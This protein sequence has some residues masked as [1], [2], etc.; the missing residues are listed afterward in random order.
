MMQKDNTNHKKNMFVFFI[1]KESSIYLEKRKVMHILLRN[2]EE[3]K[4]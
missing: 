4:R 2:Y 3:I 1:K